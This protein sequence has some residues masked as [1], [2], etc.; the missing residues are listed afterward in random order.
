MAYKGRYTIK[1]KDKYLGDPSKVIYRSLWERNA[2]R[3]CEGTPRVKKWNSEEIVIPYYYDADKRY[4]KYFPDVK[5]VMEDK[6]LLIEIK[7][8]K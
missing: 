6:T 1:N 5:M 2:F 3:W 7:P 4:H 8:E